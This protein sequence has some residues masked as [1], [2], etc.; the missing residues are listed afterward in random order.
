MALLDLH[1]AHLREVATAKAGGFTHS[2]IATQL[3]I[4]LSTVERRVHQIKEILERTPQTPN[5]N[6]F[7]LL[8]GSERI[9]G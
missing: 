9:S 1:D 2:E 6:Y 5:K 3:G 7:G 4:S 8:K